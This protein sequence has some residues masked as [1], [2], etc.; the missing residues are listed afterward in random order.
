MVSVCI[1]TIVLNLS[2]M[3]IDNTRMH[4]QSTNRMHSIPRVT[5]PLLAV[6]AQEAL[7]S[8]RVGTSTNFRV[9]HN[10]TQ[11]QALC[12]LILSNTILRLSSRMEQLFYTG[13]VI[14]FFWF[15]KSLFQRPRSSSALISHRERLRDALA[16]FSLPAID[17]NT[18]YRY[19]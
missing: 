16:W 12:R 2:P 13:V 9:R 17:R 3:V 18:Q 11:M 19:P 14:K 8:R 7:N 10:A 5:D 1:T 15:T 4:R 6:A